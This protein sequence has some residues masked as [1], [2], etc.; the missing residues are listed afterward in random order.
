[1]GDRGARA[2][3]AAHAAAA[4]AA[5]QV[6]V[7][8]SRPGKVTKGEKVVRDRRA[9]A[10]TLSPRGRHVA[11]ARSVVSV[12][13]G[14]VIPNAP[15]HRITPSKRLSR[16]ILKGLVPPSTG[17]AT[18]MEVDAFEVQVVPAIA[19]SSVTATNVVSDASKHPDSRRGVID[20]ACG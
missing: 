11:R 7:A 8:D 20:T 16:R 6:Q 17:L 5:A 15:G 1:M 10:E 2:V 12:A 9:Q 4:P 18:P 14:L 3:A 13:I 19:Y